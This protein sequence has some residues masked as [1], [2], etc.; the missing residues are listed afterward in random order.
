MR[1]ILALTLAALALAALAAGAQTVWVE[2]EQLA[3]D[4]ADPAV[5]RFSVDIREPGSYQVRLLVRGESER[6]IRLDLT[7]QPE[8]GGPAR[9][10]PFSFTGRGCG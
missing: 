8:A 10:V 4:P 9:T 3:A 6:E 7:L 2:K 1:R 5:V